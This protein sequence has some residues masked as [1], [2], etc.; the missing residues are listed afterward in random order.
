MTEPQQKLIICDNPLMHDM[1]ARLRDKRCTTPD[2]KD[3]VNRISVM[4]AYEVARFL[5]RKDVSIETPVAQMA[6]Q[7]I[8]FDKSPVLVPILRAGLGLMNG[9]EQLYP[10]ASVGHIGVYRDEETKRPVEYL[11]KL[12]KDMADRPVFLLDPMLATGHSAIYA[13]DLLKRHG[14]KEE[15][16]YAAFLIAA[17]EGIKEFQGAHPDIAMLCGA[18]DSHLNEKA[19]IVPGLGDA[20]D[21]LFGTD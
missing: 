8:A 4:L 16:I 6:A 17:P 9:F 21:R 10:D 15:H 2:F 20:G 7:H 19:Y 1:L 14:V 5:P 3:Y 18:L 13:A 11:L 12:P